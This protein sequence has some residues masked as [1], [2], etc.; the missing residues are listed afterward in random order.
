MDSGQFTVAASNLIPGPG[1]QD[2]EEEDEDS[3]MSKGPIPKKQRVY[4]SCGL[5]T[6][7][8][9]KLN[10]GLPESRA[11]CFGC[12]YVGEREAGAIP[13]EE[14]MALIDMIRDSIARTDPATLAAHVA[15]R[16]AAF[17]K[18]IN[19]NLLPEEQPLPKWS[20]ATILDHIRFHNTDPEI[21]TWI[22][23]SELQELLQVALFASVELDPVTGD[24][25]V[26]EKQAKIAMDIIKTIESVQKSDA[27]KKM[28]YSGGAHINIK[29]AAQG[30][31]ATSGKNIVNFLKR[32]R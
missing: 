23:L 19:S 8:K 10:L 30:P 31:I 21:Q 29:N 32:K 13:Y 15:K 27:T 5:E 3:E 25:Q 26:N 4:E 18:E 7:Q 22:R 20:A 24:K 17:R 14:I 6:R 16:Y 9:E 2:E 11:N 1:G 12:V 28:F